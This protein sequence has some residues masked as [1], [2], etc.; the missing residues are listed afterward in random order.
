MKWGKKRHY[1]LKK[2]SYVYV[3]DNFPFNNFLINMK[4]QRIRI[5]IY[6]NL[7]VTSN[8]VSSPLLKE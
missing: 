7:N 3:G 1:L 2:R 5:F 8:G 4:L 6:I